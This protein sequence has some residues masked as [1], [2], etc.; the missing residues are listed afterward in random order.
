M[1]SVRHFVGVFEVVIASR[2]N[3]HP[4]WGEPARDRASRYTADFTADGC[5]RIEH[6]P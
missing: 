1:V 5:A 4:M 2:G 3:A 6:N